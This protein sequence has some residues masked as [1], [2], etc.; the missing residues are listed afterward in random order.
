MDRVV[1]KEK[2]K[3]KIEGKKWY[4]WKPIV[5]WNVTILIFA[6]LVGMV[7]GIPVTIADLDEATTNDIISVVG[8][9]VGGVFGILETVFMFGYTKYCLHLVRGKEEE[10]TMPYKYVKGHIVPTLIL[11]ILV[12]LVIGLASILLIIPGIIFAIGLSFYQ[13]VY[14]DNEEL[15]SREVMRKTWDITN[16]HKAE[17]FVLGLSFIGWMFLTGLTLGILMIWLFPYMNITFMYAYE[18]LSGGAKK[19][20]SKEEKKEEPK[21]EVK[22]PVKKETKKPAKKTNKKKTA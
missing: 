17:L 19:A 4:L 9:C 8:A 21:K 3:E 7:I 10:W 20:V 15:T 2:A 6:F 18:E 11:S 22:E 1:L 5:M 13:E 14:V 12:G 16:G